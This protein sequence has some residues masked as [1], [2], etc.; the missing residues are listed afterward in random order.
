[1]LYGKGNIEQLAGGSDNEDM[2]ESS[3]IERAIVNSE[4]E[5]SPPYL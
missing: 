1:M 4:L 5:P 2:K 3:N